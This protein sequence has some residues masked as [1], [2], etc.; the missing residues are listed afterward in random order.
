MSI[1]AFVNINKQQ[2]MTSSDA[3]VVVRGIMRRI[4]GEKHKV[5]HMGTLD[6][7]AT[8]VLPVAIGKATRLFNL[9]SEKRKT[10]V[11]EFVFGSTTDTLDAWG[12]EVAREKKVVT[13]EEIQRVLPSLIGNIDQIP[14]VYSA[15][16]VDGKRAYEY[17]RKGIELDLP[18]KSVTIYDIKLIDGE[19]NH[20]RFEITCGA[21]TYIR[22]IARDIAKALG[23]YA[24]MNSLVRTQSGL[25]NLENSVDIKEFEQNP[26]VHLI[27]MEQALS[28]LPFFEIP[29]EYRKQV[30]NGIILPFDN[31]PNDTFVATID[32]K[33]VATAENKCGKL[34]LT[35][36][37]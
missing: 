22:A 1:C 10:Y 4:T 37:L 18:A 24:Y 35:L 33:V 28:F 23:T 11:A 31:M 21:G 20:F 19:D 3:V 9:L 13:K 34:V 8:G 5:G 2:N 17:A 6:P 32:G 36:R 14:P 30:L 15:K 16:S 26:F 12:E 27:P 29:I 25:F 7:M